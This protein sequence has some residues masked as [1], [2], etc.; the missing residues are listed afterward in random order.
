MICQICGK[1]EATFHFKEMIN[2]EVREIHLC[3]VCAKEKGWDKSFFIPDFSLSNLIASLTDIEISFPISETETVRCPICGL[4]Y[5][6]IKERGKIGCGSCYQTFEKY[7]TP[8]LERIQGKIYHSGKIP[9]KGEV[10]KEISK[11]IYELRKELKEAIKKE[12]YERAAE[13]RDEIHKLEKKD[14]KQDNSSRDS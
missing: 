13:I 6:D 14:E 5:K 9:H 8:L 1:R 12:E 10:K 3:E 4:S 11:R 7:L 2:G